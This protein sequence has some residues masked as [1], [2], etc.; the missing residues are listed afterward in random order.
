MNWKDKFPEGNRFFE[1]E[2]GILYCGDSLELLPQFSKDDVD[3]LLTDPPY[4]IAT[5]GG[6]IAGRRQYLKDI[7]QAKIEQG[8]D[9]SFLDGF[10]NWIVFCS[11]SQLIE[12]LNIANSRKNTRWDLLFFHKKNPAPFVNNN[13]LYDTEYIVFSR[14]QGRLFGDYHD[15]HRYKEIVVKKRLGNLHPTV[16]PLEVIE[17]LLRVGSQKEEIVL[18]PFLGSGTTAVAAEK[19]NRRWIGIEINPEY[20]EIAKKRIEEE[21][22]QP[23]LLEV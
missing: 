5:T 13:F 6:G 15:R 3:L 2:N 9:Y 21:L 16:K 7:K 17:W 8:V 23:K 19:L 11:K 4:K 18:D 1:T 22:R 12:L 14:L 10:D 20:C